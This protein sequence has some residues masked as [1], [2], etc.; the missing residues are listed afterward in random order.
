M[1][2]R[3][4][5]ASMRK[6]GPNPRP[7]PGIDGP[8]AVAASGVVVAM[9][10]MGAA[11]AT[12][13]LPPLR[14]L[15]EAATMLADHPDR[16]EISRGYDETGNRIEAAP[17]DDLSLMDPSAMLHA[18]RS[19]DGATISEGGTFSVNVVFVHDATR[20]TFTIVDQLAMDGVSHAEDDPGRPRACTDGRSLSASLRM[21]VA[22]CERIVAGDRVVDAETA[23]AMHVACRDLVL[24]PWIETMTR[25]VDRLTH[26]S[27]WSP[28]H[29]TSPATGRIVDGE[30]L[31]DMDPDARTGLRAALDRHW[32]LR[33]EVP[34]V[35]VSCAKDQ[36]T[37]GCFSRN[38]KDRTMSAAETSPVQM[39]RH[40]VTDRALHGTVAGWGLCPPPEPSS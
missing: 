18:V 33:W 28:S 32:S 6:S 34:I 16:F 21:A 17:D 4:D 3:N 38:V 37:L 25:D 39:L 40:H 2:D 22:V 15:L 29:G 23:E 8:E 36:L 35:G 20:F 11:Q 13:L 12:A 7:R 1:T 19:E 10:G 5:D 24:R 9:R 14:E 26:A 27:P 31:A 30:S